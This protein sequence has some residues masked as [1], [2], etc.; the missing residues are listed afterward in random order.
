MR[1]LLFLSAALT[2][3]AHAQ[4]FSVLAW[5]NQNYA[6]LPGGGHLL[7][8]T[9]NEVSIAPDGTV[10]FPAIVLQQGI[11][12]S[13]PLGPAAIAS[14]GDPAPGSGGY[15]FSGFSPPRAAPGG[16]VF[17][18]G[19]RGIGLPDV[20]AVY[21]ADAAGLHLC[22]LTGQPVPAPESLPRG[23]VFGKHGLSAKIANL[24]IPS[25]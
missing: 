14:V 4:T 11:F 12:R 1:T 25:A 24:W 13:T 20:T 17:V 21:L 7:S 15:N 18:A 9:S 23:Q 5:Y 3:A 19:L 2:S 16:A 10:A 22:L 6:S 8:G